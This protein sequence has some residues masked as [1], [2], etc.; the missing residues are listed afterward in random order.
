MELW[1]D[2]GFQPL[3]DGSSVLGKRAVRVLVHASAQ[4]DEPLLMLPGRVFVDNV[5][6]IAGHV[7]TV[8]TVPNSTE[9]TGMFIYERIHA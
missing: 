2:T 4:S 6:T 8:D 7:L 5:F 1:M 9:G 3:Y